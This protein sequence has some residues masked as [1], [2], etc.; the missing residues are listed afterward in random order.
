[1]NDELTKQDLEHFGRELRKTLHQSAGASDQIEA[2]SL[3]Q[4]GG[5]LDTQGDAGA[6]AEFEEVDL[7]ALDVE[8]ATAEATVAALK[9]IADG[10]YG[11][12]TRCSEWIPRS[13]LEVVPY[14]PLCVSCQEAAEEA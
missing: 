8:E 2:E 4:G 5:G 12:C 3:D 10:T 11:R 13:R 1:M 7:D 14:A 6:D 9:R